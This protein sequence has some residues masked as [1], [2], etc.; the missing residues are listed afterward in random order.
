[1]HN[2]I[3]AQPE[4]VHLKEVADALPNDY[5][6]NPKMYFGNTGA[7]RRLTEDIKAINNSKIAQHVIFT[8]F[9]KGVKAVTKEEYDKLYAKREISINVRRKNLSTLKKKADRHGQFR[10]TTGEQ[11]PYAEAFKGEI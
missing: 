2:Y 9:K 4:W 8:D 7:R 11:K 6:Y 5:P 1:L 10:L 3:L